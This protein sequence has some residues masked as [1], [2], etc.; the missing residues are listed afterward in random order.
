[1]KWANL[2][3]TKN[4]RNTYF[5]PVTITTKWVVLVLTN[6]IPTSKQN[7]IGQ[8]CTKKFMN[9]SLNV[10]HAKPGISLNKNHPQKS[11]ISHLIPGVRLDM[12]FPVLTQHL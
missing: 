12:M 8:N 10:S 11:P 1:M 7:I 4:I 9:I 2:K 3:N 6:Y 5:H